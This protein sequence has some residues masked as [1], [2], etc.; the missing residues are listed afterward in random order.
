[1]LEVFA[2]DHVSPSLDALDDFNH[3]RRRRA[4]ILDCLSKS[5]RSSVDIRIVHK[6]IGLEFYALVHSKRLLQ[7]YQN[8][9]KSW[10]ALGKDGRDPSG[11]LNNDATTTDS[12]TPPPLIP[13]NVPL[14]RRDNG[15]EQRPS[16]HVMG[17][18][19]FFC[20]D[21]C[22]PIFQ[23]LQSE[24]ENDAAIVQSAIHSKSNTIY[25]LPTHPGH[26]SAH[27][28]FGGYCYLNHAC[29][30]AKS[31]SKAC[32][33]DV[34]YH[35][36]NGTAALFYD[37]P[38]VL[39]ISLHCHPDV[40]YPFHSGFADET[41]SGD[42]KG[43]TRH[44]PLPPGTS[45]DNGYCEALKQALERIQ[46]FQPLKVVV[47]LGLDTYDQ[48]PCAI[49]RAGFTL[50]GADYCKMGKLLAQHLGNTPTVFV[51]EG[52]YRM[53]KVAQAACDVVTSFAEQRREMS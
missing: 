19:G 1:M 6:S 51:Q 45:W 11:C 27:D 31:V 12:A 52:G 37:D 8:A 41:G 30:I 43:K 14:F 13:S 29:R 44:F 22:T 46:E 49:R 10:V 26:H 25:I 35:C 34:D 20:T 17:Q 21:T 9:W 24:L 2:S 33:L 39:V 48:D 36:G 16:K 5:T 38:N 18:I 32:I 40:E 53:D 23:E 47:S 7:F 50:C 42:A 3:P 4:L 15:P 28:T